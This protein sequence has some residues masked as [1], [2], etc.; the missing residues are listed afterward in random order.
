MDSFIGVEGYSLELSQRSI[1]SCKASIL[2]LE[3]IH[4]YIFKYNSIFFGCNFDLMKVILT[5]IPEESIKPLNPLSLFIFP[6]L[7]SVSILIL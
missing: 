7:L 4:N 2:H 5:T 1:D 3:N 6:L